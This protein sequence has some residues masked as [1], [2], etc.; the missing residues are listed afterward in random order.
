ML[1]PGLS[2]AKME[3]RSTLPEVAV[4]GDALVLAHACIQSSAQC[5]LHGFSDAHLPFGWCCCE[6]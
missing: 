2:V 4:A 1:V 6:A 5:K 3:A